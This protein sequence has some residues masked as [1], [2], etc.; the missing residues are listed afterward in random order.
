MSPGAGRRAPDRGAQLSDTFETGSPPAVDTGTPTVPDAPASILYPPA[1]YDCADGVPPGPLAVRQL[2]RVE[3][4][5][6]VAF[7]LGGRLITE[8]TTLSGAL[9]GWTRHGQAQ[10]FSPGVGSARG[11]NLLNDGGVVVASGLAIPRFGA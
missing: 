5:E 3:T 1:P 10:L 8:S 2:D 6:G 4:T 11:L 7:D 9:V